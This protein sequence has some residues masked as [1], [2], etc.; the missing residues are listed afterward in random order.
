MSENNRSG[1]GIFA[2]PEELEKEITGKIRPVSINHEFSKLHE[3][4]TTQAIRFIAAY[5][6][7]LTLKTGVIPR[8]YHDLGSQIATF[9]ALLMTLGIPNSEHSTRLSE[10][11]NYLEESFCNQ[12]EEA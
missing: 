3:A 10:V 8:K 1:K 4:L 7:Y 9:E 12:V 2:V 6:E 11:V 5:K